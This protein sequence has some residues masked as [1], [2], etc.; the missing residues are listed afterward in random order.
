MNSKING[1]QAGA[2]ARASRNEEAAPTEYERLKQQKHAITKR[3]EGERIGAVL[4]LAHRYTTQPANIWRTFVPH[5]LGE[6]IELKEF[7]TALENALAAPGAAIAARE[8]EATVWSGWACQYPGKLPRLYGAKEIAEV[9]CDYE[10]GD[11]LLFLASQDE[12]PAPSAATGAIAVK[13]AQ[14]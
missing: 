4:T 3:Q 2:V 1:E 7:R 14:P 9:N 5:S 10:N 8:Q 12:A 6:F 11:R 13:D